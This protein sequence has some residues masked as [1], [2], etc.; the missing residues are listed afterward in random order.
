MRAKREC[1]LL[2]AQRIK[3]DAEILKD[4]HHLREKKTLY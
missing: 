3:K 1:T 2:D 4:F